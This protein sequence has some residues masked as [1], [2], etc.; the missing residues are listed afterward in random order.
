MINVL[1]IEDFGGG[2]VTSTVDCIFGGILDAQRLPDEKRRLRN[3][4]ESNGIFLHLNF[5]D[6]LSFIK[7]KS[8]TVDLIILDID[9]ESHGSGKELTTETLATLKKHYALENPDNESQ[10]NAALAKLKQCAGYHL[11]VELIINRQYPKDK[12]LF[13]SN[14]GENLASINNAF[15]NAMIEM[16]VIHKKSDIEIQNLV[17]AACLKNSYGTLRRAIIDGC[18]SLQCY[19]QHPEGIQFNSLLKEKDK[20]IEP[21]DLRN[22]LNLLAGLLPLQEPLAEEKH[23][24][25]KLFIRTLSHE[26]ERKL[27]YVNIAHGNRE[28]SA[29]MNIMKN[30][31]NWITHSSIFDGVSEHDVAFLFICNMRAFFPLNTNLELYEQKLLRLFNGNTLQR[32]KIETGLLSQYKKLSKEAGNPYNIVSFNKMLTDYQLHHPNP[33]SGTLLNGLYQLFWFETSPGK[34]KNSSNSGEL[35]YEFQIDDRYFDQEA[36]TAFFTR[37]A[38]HIYP[39]SSLQ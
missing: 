24:L 36:G 37:F 34:I 11:Y 17:T 18:K 28:L 23:N 39:K 27:S 35:V 15:K 26:W 4:L 32:P 5:Q 13:C 33:S 20:E 19:L 3:K 22:Y 31:R 38:E 9:L 2:E 25:Y 29:F 6:G 21:N 1:W 7:E 14:H 16:P 10:L 30:T 8:H 12:I